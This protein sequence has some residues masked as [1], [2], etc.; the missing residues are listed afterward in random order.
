MAG[1]SKG[2]TYPLRREAGDY[3]HGVGAEVI[4]SNVRKIIRATAASP[5]GRLRGSYP[6]RMDFG[7]QIRRLLHT[8]LDPEVIKAMAIIFIVE[9]VERWEPRA[10]LEIGDIEVL[11][12]DNGRAVRIPVKF[13]T[14]ETEPWQ[15]EEHTIG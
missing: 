14:S 10:I 13:R 12:V 9:P 5:D 2:L 6:W 4:R 15:A 11:T 7:T 3:A 8:D 1:E